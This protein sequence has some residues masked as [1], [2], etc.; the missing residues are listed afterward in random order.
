MVV[1]GGER[2]T[3]GGPVPLNDLCI[4]QPDTSRAW[5]ITGCPTIGIRKAALKTD[6]GGLQLIG[7]Y[8]FLSREDARRT[9]LPGAQVLA[10]A[11][12]I[13]IL[14]FVDAE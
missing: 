8:R 3:A 9:G 1:A 14:G 11:H 2:W 5:R 6:D 7:G 10:N 12:Q 13:R 4:M